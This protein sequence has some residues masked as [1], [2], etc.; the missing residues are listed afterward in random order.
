MLPSF[1]TSG[2]TMGALLCPA[3]GWMYLHHSRVEV[4]DA[5]KEDAL[6]G[7]HVTVD[8]ERASVSTDLT[9]NPSARR[10]GLTILLECERCQ[11]TSELRLAQ[12]KGHTFLTIHVL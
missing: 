5:E 2:T 7:L 12:H 11:A 3:C 1:D 8:G 4:Y 10:H 6:T 9:G